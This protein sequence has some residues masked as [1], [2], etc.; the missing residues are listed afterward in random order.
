MIQ[1]RYIFDDQRLQPALRGQSPQSVTRTGRS[2]LSRC[3]QSPDDLAEE[4][5]RIRIEHGF[6]RTHAEDDLWS[7]MD[8]PIQSRA[9]NS[10]PCLRNEISAG[11][12]TTTS[13]LSARPRIRSIHVANRWWAPSRLG[14]CTSRVA[15]FPR[16]AASCCRASL[17]PLV[18]LVQLN[19]SQL[20]IQ[21]RKS[22]AHDSGTPGRN[23]QLQ[24]GHVLPGGLALAQAVKPEKPYGKCAIHVRLWLIRID[25][26][27]REH[28]T[29]LRQ[30]TTRVSRTERALQVHGRLRLFHSKAREDSQQQLLELIVITGAL[31]SLG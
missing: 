21:V 23:K 3:L 30:H 4:Q 31:G 20:A 8:R 9:R 13:Q 11:E 17:S 1:P 18:E 14:Q 22:L 27:Y 19:R 10:S 29:A 12:V 5:L 26:Y 24:S 15:M 2:R 16:S 28:G 7:A 25:A 6:R